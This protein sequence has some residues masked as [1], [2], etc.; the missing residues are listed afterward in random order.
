MSGMYV[1]KEQQGERHVFADGRRIGRIVKE[2]QDAYRGRN[3]TEHPLAFSCTDTIREL[4][5]GIFEWTRVYRIR[6]DCDGLRLTMDFAAAHEADYWMI[7]GVSYNGNLWGKGLEPKGFDRDGEPWSYASHRTNVPGATYSQGKM[8]SVT[9]FGAPDKVGASLT[10]SCSLFPEN[11]EIVHRLSWP[12]EE[13]PLVYAARDQYEP[14]HASPPLAYR[15]GDTVTLKAYLVFEPV[16]GTGTPY[17][18]MLDF[19]W[20]IHRHELQPWHAPEHI[21]AYGI[22]F[23]KESLYLEDGEFRGFI[24]G[25]YWDGEAWAQKKDTPYEIGWVGQNASLANSLISDY[26]R[27]GT[28]DSLDMGIGV[29]DAWAREA[30]LPNGLFR[31]RM[32][33]GEREAPKKQEVLDA[34][35]MSQAALQYLEAYETLK[36]NG[37][38]KPGYLR[39]AQNICDFTVSAMNGAGRIGKSWDREGNSLDPE[40]TV[41]AFLILPLL[42]LYTKTLNRSYADAAAKAYC[43]YM[44]GFLRDGYTTAGALDTYCIDKESAMPLLKAGLQLYSLTGEALYLRNSEMISWYLAT[45]Q[46]HQSIPFPEGSPLGRLNYDSFGGTTVSTQHQHIDHYALYF[47][48]DWLELAA[49]TGS[50]QWQERARAIWMNATAVISDGTLE[51]TGRVRPAGGQDEG[52]CHTR[53]H[54][55]RGEFFGVSQW[56]VAWPTAFRLELLRKRKDWTIFKGKAGD[57]Q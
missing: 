7:P 37:I 50:R 32:Y 14:A 35:N 8:D 51:V 2:G 11:G 12:E 24:W 56:L 27:N 1:W 16:Q 22:R 4:E 15:A 26:L 46:V 54:T 41:G 20:R 55:S 18:K 48:E 43:Y 42:A 49:H 13:K 33:Y 30:A 10:F 34:C 57:S 45:W 53:W 31:V 6:R 9:L 21:W 52:F 3:A 39:I 25:R 17:K 38:D 44:N 40:G 36:T 29:L 47:F 28:Q 19:A 5:N 23:V